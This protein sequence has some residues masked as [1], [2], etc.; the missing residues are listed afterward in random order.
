MKNRPVE[1]QTVEKQTVKNR[2]VGIQ[3]VWLDLSDRPYADRLSEFLNRYYG[4]YL[5]VH[6]ES[7]KGALIVPE[8]LILLTDEMPGERELAL[9]REG[10]G[11]V[12]KMSP[13]EGLDPYQP[14]HEIAKAIFKAALEVGTPETVES[15]NPAEGPEGAAEPGSGADAGVHAGLQ[16]KRI[17]TVTA[18]SGGLGAGTLARALAMEWAQRGRTLLLELS[19]RSPWRMYEQPPESGRSLSDVLYSLAAEP[20]AMWEERL[21]SACEKQSGGYWFAAPCEDPEDFLCLTTEETEALCRLLLTA[22]DYVIAECGQWISPPV[23]T[24][25]EKSHELCLLSSRREE[26][27]MIRRSLILPAGTWWTFIREWPEVEVPKGKGQN[28]LRGSRGKEEENVFFL[29]DE[30]N[31]WEIRDGLRVLRRDS[32]L[33][34]RVRE[35]VR[36]M[37]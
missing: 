32:A 19:L 7:V 35:A 10:F 5:D 24:I 12:L 30:R 17:C 3:T 25:M 28:L 1:K 11:R 33:A 6:E 22:F 18:T 4:R 8:K 13:V 23:K 14:A 9:I 26:D 2:S 27:E 31:L 37:G 20:E 21:L 36:M 15:P 16:E 29:P 34:E